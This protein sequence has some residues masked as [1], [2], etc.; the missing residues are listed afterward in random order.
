MNATAQANVSSAAQAASKP[1]AVRDGATVDERI[2]I[3]QA[4]QA[5][6]VQAKAQATT[7]S[8]QKMK[9]AL[10]TTG[11]YLMYAAA[12]AA[13]AAAAVYAYKRFTNG[14]SVQDVAQVA[15]AAVDAAA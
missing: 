1:A 2:E 9:A 14:G 4:R 10:K 5:E 8:K 15:Q 7:Q 3:A 11:K 13:T 6:A 12:G